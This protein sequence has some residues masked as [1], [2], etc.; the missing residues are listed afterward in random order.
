MVEVAGS[1]VVDIRGDVDPL[2]RS[3]GRARRQAEQFDR[4]L[5]RT[6][7][8]AE[9][10][11]TS[12]RRVARENDRFAAST[13]RA[14]SAARDLIAGFAGGLIVESIHSLRDLIRVL[15]NVGMAAIKAASDVEEMKNLL[16]VTFGAATADVQKWAETTADEVR[17]SR[18]ELMKMAGDFAAFLK[19]IGT[20]PDQI[21]PMSKSLTRLTI[22]LSSF[23]NMA[24]RDVFSRLLSGLAGEAE[25]V[26]MLGVDLSAVALEQ[27]LFRMGITK[28]SDELTQAEK[29]MARYSIVMRQTADAQGDATRTMDSYENLVKSLGGEL[30]DLQVTIGEELL[31][32]A[33]EFLKWS[34]NAVDS[35][36]KLISRMGE[37]RNEISMLMAVLSPLS[38]SFDL[39][40]MLREW[41]LGKD[42][43]QDIFRSGDVGIGGGGSG[44]GEPRVDM[45]S[46]ADIKANERIDRVVESLKHQREQLGR[47][48][49]GQL[50]YNA[51]QRAG[52]DVDHARAGEV[53]KLAGALH[54]ASMA[55]ERGQLFAE[56]ENMARSA[57]DQAIHNEL[58]RQNISLNQEGAQAIATMAGALFDAQLAYSLIGEEMEHNMSPMERYAE[59]LRSINSLYDVG[60]L[61][62]EEYAA[63]TSA[64]ARRVGADWDSQARHVSDAM[65][66]IVQA[67]ARGSEEAKTV[68][69]V[70][71]I[72]QGLI[73]TYLAV[74]KA[75]AEIPPPASYVVAGASLA[76]GLSY[77][78]Q[79]KSLAG[80]G[81]VSGPGTG[82]SDSIPARLSNGEFVINARATRQFRPVL[83]RINKFAEGGPV[84][85]GALAGALPSMGGG[86]ALRIEMVSRVDKNGNLRSFV[87]GV[88][89]R[90]AGRM[91]T[92]STP[93][94]VDRASSRTS[95]DIKSGALDGA[96]GRRFG[97]RP[98][99]PAR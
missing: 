11:A 6:R 95:T 78:A 74:T 66:I 51:L 73:N 83:E 24:E 75:L 10:V 85:G 13:S 72:A 69:K 31:P 94:I 16:S 29:I 82:M 19:P 41:L 58:L 57:R 39:G 88:S 42:E 91:V 14:A 92:V 5:D 84:G 89:G 4:T 46:R 65:G 98:Q 47:T 34:V 22:D 68:S 27:E 99:A 48:T 60:R 70:A 64:A 63:A 17:R 45:S 21:E 20:A 9:R 3:M 8:A 26:R 33:I 35:I 96:L 86:G 53:M 87:E 79:I 44:G 23:R 61:T 80:G 76:M 12:T 62:A 50:V 18:F 97:Q 93:A 52:I 40:V 37:F 28:T 67:T 7:V 36:E 56:A 71:A 77:V 15:I 1:V 30:H 55:F 32:V 2:A 38:T 90:I 49:R 43:I 54:D 25:S 59:I 81:F